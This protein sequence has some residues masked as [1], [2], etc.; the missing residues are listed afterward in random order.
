M[1]PV[2]L[3]VSSRDNA[4][5]I[6][7]KL[8]LERISQGRFEA[9]SCGLNPENRLYEPMRKHWAPIMVE[10][11]CHRAQS[12]DQALSMGSIAHI[13]T[14]GVDRAAFD[15]QDQDL[16]HVQSFTHLALKDPQI[17]DLRPSEIASDCH[18]LFSQMTR[19]IQKWITAQDV[20]ASQMLNPKA[21]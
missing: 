7:A 5:S 1:K 17:S 20:L 3:F 18:D 2:V 12:L 8:L 4:R 16:A 13:I 19:L 15:I 6:M 10:G 9:R 14:L 21:A 11:F